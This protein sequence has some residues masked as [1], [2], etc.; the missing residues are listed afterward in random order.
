MRLLVTGG[1]GYVGSFTARALAGAGH[2]VV[3]LDN[4]TT[5][6]RGTAGALPVVAGDCRDVATVSALLGHH[7]I[8]AVLHFAGLS[9]VGASTRDPAGYYAANVGGALGLLEAMRAAGVGRLVFSSS[10]AVYG[11]PQRQPIREDAPIAPVN[12]YGRSKAMVERILEDAA[13]AGQVR[14]TCLR[15]FNAAGA[16]KDGRWGEDHRPESHLIPRVLRAILDG[17][18]VTVYGSDYP[19]PD[20]T[21]VRDYIHVEDLAQAHL[22]ALELLSRQPFSALNLGTGQGHSVREILQA[23][24]TVTG[25]TIRIEQ[26]PRRDGDP[27]VLVA[28]PDAGRSKLGWKPECSDINGIIESAYRWHSGV[29]MESKA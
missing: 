13:G 17:T 16:S 20:G 22:K 21:A 24:H 29:N 10:A 6:H 26:G 12:P 25:K 4:L 23:A 14:A 3:I 8:E 28:S 15:Y 7:R 9:E 11:E 27:A 18:P 1:L 19:T 2:D 5:G